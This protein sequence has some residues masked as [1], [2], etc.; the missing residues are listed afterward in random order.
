MRSRRP[1]LQQGPLRQDSREGQTGCDALGH[2]DDVRL[3]LPMLHREHLAGPAEAR[4]NLVRDQQDPVLPGDLTQAGQE[5]G[6]WHDVATFPDDG[7][8][9]DGS[10]VFRIDELVEGQIE[11]LLPIARARFGRM[12]AA[13]RSVAVRVGRVIDAPR[14]GLEVAAVDILGGRQR[15][16]LRRAA[17]EAVA[18]SQDDRPTG[19]DPSELDRCLDGLRSAVGEESAPALA[20][21]DVRQALVQAEPRLVVDDVLLAVQKLGGLGLDRGDDARM[22]MSRARD[23]D[24]RRVVE[25]ALAI[26]RDEPAAL[27]AI[28]REVGD[29]APDRRNHRRIGDRRGLA[30]LGSGIGRHGLDPHLMRA[31]RPLRRVVNATKATADRNTMEPTTL[32][33]TGSAFLMIPQ[34]QIGKVLVVPDTK[35]VI[36]KSSIERENA[37]KAAAITPGNMSGKVTRQKVV[38]SFAPRSIA[39]SSRWRSN[40]ARRAFTV[41]TT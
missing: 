14:Q 15:H 9:D 22:R 27:A 41:T 33:C 6:W 29:A 11:L 24:S 4:L 36:T 37:S 26:R 23:A 38:H 12:R 5:A 8:D 7:L 18:K 20:R 30:F 32:I 16:G 21:H 39:A 25:V 17:V 31:A 34:T 19:R 35:L 1:L 40:P 28:D 13:R 3:D 10:H 2:H